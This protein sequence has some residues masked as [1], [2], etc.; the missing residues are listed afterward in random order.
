MIN[1][2]I[3]GLLLGFLLV[4]V[5]FA[6]P[7]LSQEQQ[8]RTIDLPIMVKCG[9]EDVIMKPI[10]DEYQEIPFAKMLVSFMAPN[11]QMLS[12]YGTIWA[13]AKTGTWSYIVNFPD[14]DQVC[15][16]LGGREFGPAT[17]GQAS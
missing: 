12:G 10:Y 13:N 11:G 17:K 15:Y 8:N 9:P 3:Q 5:N 1:K 14:S 4:F 7:A 16:F 6:T 2:A